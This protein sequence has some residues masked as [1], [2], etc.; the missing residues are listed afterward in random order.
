MSQE[1]VQSTVKVIKLSDIITL[2]AEGKTRKEINAL[3]GETD[4]AMKQKVWSHPKLKNKKS[5]KPANIAL[6]DDTE[7]VEEIAATQETPVFDP[8]VENIVTDAGTIGEEAPVE[9]EAQQEAV[10]EEAINYSPGEAELNE[11]PQAEAPA[12]QRGTW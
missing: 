1:S 8:S 6:E 2:M 12:T 11:A 3:Y 4:A 10:I 7:E 9:E 5:A